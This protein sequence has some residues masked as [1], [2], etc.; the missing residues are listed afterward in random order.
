MKTIFTIIFSFI[1]SLGYSQ[2]Y[3]F[4]KPTR[5][6]KNVNSSAE[7]SMP[8]LSK[9][10]KKLFFV[11]T[12][13]SGNVGGKNSGQDIWFSELN[14][15]NQ[16]STAS[17]IIPPL[18]NNRNNAIIGYDES[19]NSLYLLDSYGP[20]SKGIDGIAKSLWRY[21]RY[22]EPVTIKI[23]GLSAQNSFVGF[24]INEA[25]NV[26]LVSMAGNNS[27]GNEDIYVTLKDESGNWGELVNL[28][29][30]INTSEYEISPFLLDEKTLIFASKGHEGYGDCDLYMSKRL[31]DNSWVLWSKPVNLGSEI[32][33]EGFDAFLSVTQNKDVFFVSNRNSEN[34]DIYRSSLIEEM[35]EEMRAEI[36]PS[37]YKLSETEIQQLLGMPLN[38]SIYFALDSY[39]LRP[40]SKELLDFLI[41]KLKTNSEYFIELIGHTDIEGTETYNLTLSQRRAD[42]VADYLF[43]QGIGVGR[44]DTKGVGEKALLFTSG[45]EE[46]LSKNRRVEIFITEERF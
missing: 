2:N 1:L 43:K 19:G 23:K 16:W 39:E 7:E 12:L 29:P 41:E 32:N 46:Q 20:P 11:R 34:T 4:S 10:G 22:L 9:D 21:D 18:N 35:Q 24:Y 6:S 42:E 25:E 13:F 45:T 8:L 40:E 44:V 33:S 27:L 37:K 15:N 30:T 14:E 31:Y 17:N 28:G 3:S 38:R 26:L 36:N 5:L